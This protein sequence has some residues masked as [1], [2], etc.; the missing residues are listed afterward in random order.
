[1]AAVTIRRDLAEL[2][3]LGLLVSTHGGARRVER[4]GTPKPFRVRQAEDPEAKAAI[5]RTASELIGDD[6]AVILTTARRR[7]P[8]RSG[9]LAGPLRRCV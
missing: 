7:K 9:W 6:D 2:E 5:A 3:E 1:M 8:L 4:R